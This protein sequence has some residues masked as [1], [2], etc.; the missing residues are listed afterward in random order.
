MRSRQALRAPRLTGLAVALLCLVGCAA[1]AARRERLPTDWRPVHYDVALTF[2]D[3]LTTLA[4][5]ETRVTIVVLRPAVRLIDFDFGALTVDGVRVGAEA[6]RYE[7]RG[8]RLNVALPRPAHAREQI[9]IT[10]TYHGRPAD[11]LIFTNDTDGHASATGDNWP[12]RVHNWIPTLDHPAAKAT[13]NFT[14]NAPERYKVVANGS[15]VGGGSEELRQTWLYQ[16]RAPVP[17]YC[18]VVAV[19]EFARVSEPWPRQDTPSVLKWLAYYVPPSAEGRARASFAA[20]PVALDLYSGLVAPF[21]YEK[22]AHIVGATRFGGMENSSAIVYT[23][24]LL[25]PR[26]DEPV[27]RRFGVRRGLVEV[28]AHETAHQWFGDAVTPATWADLWLS[29]GFATYFAGLFVERAEGAPEFRA[30]M[31]RAADK[32]IAYEREPRPPVY[33]RDTENLNALLNA[34]SY[35]KGAWVLHMLRARFGDEHFMAAL[36][37]YYRAHLH[38]NATTED[39]RAAFEA[40]TGAPLREFFARWVYGGGHPRYELTWAWEPGGARGGFVRLTLRQTQAAAPFLTPLPVEFVNA[41]TTRRVTL[42]PAGRVT[43]AR[44]PAPARPDDV[45]LDPDETILKEARVAAAR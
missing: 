45:R 22:L 1:H 44:F 10:V 25:D 17:P 32:V 5:A 26:P 38:A 12:D 39:L 11:G 6:A 7:Q 16:E 31:R 27:S 33:D 13:V 40:E 8:G 43:V 30:Y 18:M 41:G 3:R 4:R 29:E 34:N 24:T 23:S 28:V 14:V 36:R 19:G 20:A 9:T 42:T 37:R 15:Y 2:D 21:P 35:Q